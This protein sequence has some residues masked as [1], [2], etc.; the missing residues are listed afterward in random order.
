[1]VFPTVAEVRCLSGFS[2]DPADHA[3][4]SYQISCQ[5]DGTLESP[6][7]KCTAINCGDAPAVE[8]AAVTGSTL[9]GESL[10][11]TADEGYSLDASATGPKS[12]E[13]RCLKTGEFS[14]QQ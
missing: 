9:F 12:F 3:T 5:A 8:H 10:T 6:S 14:A 11:A 13:F 7:D 1:M 2:R 4:T